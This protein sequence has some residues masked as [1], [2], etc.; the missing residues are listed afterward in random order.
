MDVSYEKVFHSF[1]GSS[2]GFNSFVEG[3]EE[4]A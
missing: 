1:P 4:E 2:C 3:E